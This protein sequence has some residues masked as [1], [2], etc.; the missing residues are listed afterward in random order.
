M[1]AHENTFTPR[2]SWCYERDG[3]ARTRTT[4]GRHGV[5]TRSWHRVV[6]SWPK[7]S[8]GGLSR[9][10]ETSETAAAFPCRVHRHPGSPHQYTLATV[11]LAVHTQ[12]SAAWGK[13]RMCTRS[14]THSSHYRS[15]E[16]TV[17]RARGRNATFLAARSIHLSLV[18]DTVRIRCAT[19][20]YQR[21]SS[22]ERTNEF[23]CAA[24]RKA[25]RPTRER[26]SLRANAWRAPVYQNGVFSCLASIG[27]ATA[28][29]PYGD[30]Y[31]QRRPYTP[32]HRFR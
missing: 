8:A 14:S 4:T 1:G 20:S 30:S 29:F 28:N 16:R 2:A 17:L 27:E 18:N 10:R 24:Q 26:V 15:T 11:S 19:H 9:A 25:A 23:T 7:V 22:T 6:L 32:R 21:C 13:I 12:L 5:A 31:G 3:Y